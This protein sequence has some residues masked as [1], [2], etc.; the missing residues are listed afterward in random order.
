MKEK[1]G[2]GEAVKELGSPC[3][4]MLKSPNRETEETAE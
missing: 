4:G 2:G 3:T 1:V